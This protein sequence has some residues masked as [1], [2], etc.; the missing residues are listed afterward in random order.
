MK[1]PETSKRK[2]VRKLHRNGV[3][4]DIGSANKRLTEK[5]K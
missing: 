4:P 1:G 2:D 5:K 3:C